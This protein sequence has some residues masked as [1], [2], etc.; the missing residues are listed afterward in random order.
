MKTFLGNFYR[1][2]AFFS[3]HT[4]TNINL[5]MFI[6]RAFQNANTNIAQIWL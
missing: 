4:G 2:L 5:Y 3:G 6:F 1:H